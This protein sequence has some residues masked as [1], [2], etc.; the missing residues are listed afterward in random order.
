MTSFD[1]VVQCGSCHPGGGPLEFDRGGHRYDS[2]MADPNSGMVS[3]GEN[4]L[5]GDYYKAMWDKSG[6]LEA[7]CFLC[8]MPEYNFSARNQQ[9]NKLNFRWAATAGS[10]LA[11]VTGSVKEEK[12]V[13]VSYDKS[14]FDE[15]GRLSPHIVRE[16][17]T[18]TCLNCHAKPDG[19]SEV[20]ISERARTFT[21][22]QD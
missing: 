13:K 16:P 11:I 22:P 12:T 8:H 6:V 5:D 14:R 18:Q 1:F 20:L 10:G 19:K 15:D 21:L 2:V 7:D 3:G 4:S 9:I 17:R